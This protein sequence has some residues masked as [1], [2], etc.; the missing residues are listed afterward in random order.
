MRSESLLLA[1]EKAGPKKE[2]LISEASR[3]PLRICE[4]LRELS[5]TV[6]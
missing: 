3:E 5:G 4:E 6:I 2:L 1:E